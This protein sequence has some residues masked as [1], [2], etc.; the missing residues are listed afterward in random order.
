MQ[1]D[2]AIVREQGVDFAFVA[3]RRTALNT[4][5]RES[6]VATWSAELG[7][8]AALMSQD[9]RGRPTF[10]GRTDIAGFLSNVPVAAL[11][12]WRR[13]TIN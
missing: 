9:T 5:N 2:V 4:S 10:Y 12:P 7:V 3:V 11:P 13:A 1:C 6:L 8:P